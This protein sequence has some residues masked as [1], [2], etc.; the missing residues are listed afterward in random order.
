MEL[1]VSDICCGE[2]QCPPVGKPEYFLGVV[3][4]DESIFLHCQ[5]IHEPSLAVSNRF[6]LNNHTLVSWDH[7]VTRVPGLRL[8]SSLAEQVEGDSSLSPLL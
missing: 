4:A 2:N 6:L 7:D 3:A 8:Y 5:Q 1:A